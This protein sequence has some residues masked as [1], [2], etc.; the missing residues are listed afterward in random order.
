MNTKNWDL[1]PFLKDKNRDFA[2]YHGTILHKKWDFSCN[3]ALI[4][5]QKR[6][7]LALHVVNRP[8]AR[9]SVATRTKTGTITDAKAQTQNKKGDFSPN[10]PLSEEQKWGP[11]VADVSL[12][13][14]KEGPS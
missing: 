14:Q 13:V 12:S 1:Y 9:I 11:L 7:P 10:L 6:G 4:S 5:E 2:R 3:S 8:K